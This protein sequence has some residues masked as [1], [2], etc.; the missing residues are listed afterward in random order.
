MKY[1]HESE[2]KSAKKSRNT[3][4]AIYFLVLAVYLLVS[5]GCLLWYSTL[6]YKSP[7]IT[8][9][10]FIHYPLTFAFII[11]SFIYL[12]ITYKRANKHYKLVFN[13]VN[14]LKEKSVANFLEVDQTL[15]DKDGVDMKA[16]LFLQFNKRKGDYFERKVL[17]FADREIPVI[18]HNATVEFITQG[19]VLIEYEITEYPDQEENN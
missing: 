17:V 2:L 19:N 12:F 15:Q 13:M 8:K 14:G 10:K 11:F 4:R 1:F 3:Y 16:L 7:V 6:P 18:P 9:I 5:V